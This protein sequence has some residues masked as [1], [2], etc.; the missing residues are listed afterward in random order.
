MSLDKILKYQS[1]D[2]KLYALQNDFE[3]SEKRKNLM[4][5]QNSFNEKNEELARVAKET[6][7]LF[8]AFE[9]SGARLTELDPIEE[10]INQDINSIND[11]TELDLYDKSLLKYEECISSIEKEMNKAARRLN[12]IKYEVQ[13]LIEQRQEIGNQYVQHKKYHDKEVLEM[14]Q[15]AA[16]IMMEL[17]ELKE[18]LDDKLY[19]KYMERRNAR[20][21]PAFVEYMDGNCAGCGMEIFIEVNEKLTK[22]GDMAE[23]PE[24]RRIVYK[25]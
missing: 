5:L 2:L 25:P 16:P 19:E 8:I 6:Q 3:K 4:I 15:K 10:E 18:G 12:E 9:K 17:K 7:E 23:C 22:S 21:M 20:K 1:V 14:K 11:L 13:K 24:C